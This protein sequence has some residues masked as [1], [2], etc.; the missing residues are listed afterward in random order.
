L[1][2]LR[3]D[4]YIFGRS[5]IVRELDCFDCEKLLCDASSI[6]GI[7]NSN[8]TLEDIS[9]FGEGRS[10]IPTRDPLPTLAEQCLVLN[11]E[12]DKA[13][14]IRNKILRFYFVGEF[15]VS[16][17]VNMP[18][19]VFPEVT[20]RIEGDDQQSAIYRLLQRIPELCTVSDRVSSEQ[21]D[22]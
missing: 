22:N 7:T 16:P 1:K 19:S 21:F 18:V 17:F 2:S 5:H 3:I 11:K 13:K 20:S 4:R 14:L 6:E 8:H 15:D 10:G 12:V 9:I